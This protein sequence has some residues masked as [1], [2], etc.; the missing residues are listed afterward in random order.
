MSLSALRRRAHGAGEQA[1]AQEGKPE[2]LAA[3]TAATGGR[4]FTGGS[5]TLSGKASEPAPAAAPAQPAAVVHTITFYNNG[6]VVNGGPLRALDDPK[7]FEFMVRGVRG[8]G[9]G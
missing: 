3:A 1:G 7:N 4:A 6:F 5:R 2:D 8:L 9:A